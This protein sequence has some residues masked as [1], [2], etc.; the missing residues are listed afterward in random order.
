MNITQNDT[1]EI[2]N[3]LAGFVGEV[4]AKHLFIGYGLFVNDDMFALYNEGCLYLRAKGELAEELE[5]YGAVSWVVHHQEKKLK[6]FDYYWLPKRITTDEELY[7]QFL[8]KSLEQIKQEK[9]ENKLL[10][11][12]RIRDMAN[13]SMKYERL[14]AKVGIFTVTQFRMLGAINSYIRLLKEGLVLGIDVFWKFAAALQNRRVE[15]LTEEEKKELLKALNMALSN[16]GLKTI[17]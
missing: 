12:N 9:L 6:A 16:A 17:K 11:L 3:L 7:K 5:K 1:L 14:L 8:L 10:K 4:R 15:T 13:L 2:R